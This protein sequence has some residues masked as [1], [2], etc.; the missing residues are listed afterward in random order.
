MRD[1]RAVGNVHLLSLLPVEPAK[2]DLAIGT[3][4]ELPPDPT[5]FTENPKFLAIMHEVLRR[6]AHQDP[7][8]IAQA[9][10]MAST[11]GSGLGSGGFFL[12]GQRDRRRRVAHGGGGGAGG[13]GAGAASIQGGAGGGGVGGWIHV[14]DS[15]HVPDFGRIADPQDIFGSVEVDA[16]GQF[17]GGDGNYQPSGTYRVI[18][19]EGILGLSPF[20]LDKLVQRLSQINTSGSS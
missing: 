19:R 7:G 9:A 6:H 14:S 18:T 11:A 15:R 13:D 3:T 4:T 10:A 1:L 17:V 12:P 20:I 8:V 5:S 2:P 16:R